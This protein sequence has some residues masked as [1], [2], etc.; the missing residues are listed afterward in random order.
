M[1]TEYHALRTTAPT[2]N[3]NKG[4][5]NSIT[6]VLFR[7]TDSTEASRQVLD[8]RA[9]KKSLGRTVMRAALAQQ[10]GLDARRWVIDNRPSGR[11]TI[12]SAPPGFNT[13]KVSLSHSGQFFVAAASSCDAIGVD[14]ECFRKR[15]YREI[16]EFSG[17]PA[18]TWGPISNLTS[19]RFF[20]LWTLWEA[21]I[22][23]AGDQDDNDKAD[24]FAGLLKKVSPGEPSAANLEDWSSQSWKKANQFWITVV[25]RRGKS[26]RPGLYELGP[27]QIDDDRPELRRL[28]D[29]DNFDTSSRIR[30]ESPVPL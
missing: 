22:K 13:T 5:L 20:Q 19:D 24:L 11:P 25:A 14:I 10:T 23:A 29:L 16:A 4:N 1:S 12:M 17:W 7:R 8:E 26:P 2:H 15:R 27:S 30:A 9:H 18:S 21:A 3:S 28:D 6:V